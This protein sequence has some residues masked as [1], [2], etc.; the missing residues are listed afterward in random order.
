VNYNNEQ[1]QIIH[2]DSPHILVLASAGSGKTATLIG[3]INYLLQELNVQCQQIL[4][5]TFT[6][7]AAHEVM[8]R[9]KKDI[10]VST[11]HKFALAHINIQDFNLLGENNIF[12]KAEMK[13]ISLYKNHYSSRK[14]LVYEQYQKFL[15]DHHCWDFDDLLVILQQKL[16]NKELIF[17]YHYI[18]IDEFQDTNN[19]QYECLKLLAQNS[20]VFAVGDPDQAIYAFRGANR[21]IINFFKNDF[22]PQ[23]YLLINNYRSSKEI[24]DFCNNLIQ[25]NIFRTPKNLIS[26]KPKSGLVEIIKVF[27]QQALVN[28]IIDTLRNEYPQD[29]ALLYRVNKSSFF[30]REKL[31]DFYTLNNYLLLSIHQAKGLEFDNVMIIDCNDAMTPGIVENIMELEEERRILFVGCSRARAKLILLYQQQIGPLSR[32]LR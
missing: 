31:A 27:D 13:N 25:R 1:L 21:R 30:L 4:C 16:V 2:S 8:R 29:W 7:R 26:T 18:F 3:R 15:L 32:F 28:F 9:L 20:K 12:T 6:H 14:P 23:Q 5:L 19:L 22:N 10:W 17:D 24:I 11:F